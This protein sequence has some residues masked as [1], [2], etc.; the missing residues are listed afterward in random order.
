MVVWKNEENAVFI[1]SN[2]G[3]FALTAL[4]GKIAKEFRAQ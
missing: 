3:D 1:V 4:L 2:Y